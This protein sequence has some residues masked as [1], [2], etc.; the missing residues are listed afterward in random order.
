MW[1]ERFSL[2]ERSGVARKGD[3]SSDTKKEKTKKI[4]KETKPEVV[5]E[6]TVSQ[7]PLAELVSR[8]T[9]YEKEVEDADAIDASALQNEFDALDFGDDESSVDD[10]SID[11]R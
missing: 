11:L 3:T 4:P 9:G 6:E 10:D 1:H 8:P 5:K 7:A 2:A